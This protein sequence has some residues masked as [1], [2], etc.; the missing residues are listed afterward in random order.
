MNMGSFEN[1]SPV[2]VGFTSEMVVVGYIMKRM[3]SFP[4]I[5]E[6]IVLFLSFSTCIQFANEVLK[7]SPLFPK[8]TILT[9]ILSINF[10]IIQIISLRIKK[11][12]SLIMMLTFKSVSPYFCFLLHFSLAKTLK[13]NMTFN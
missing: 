3:T 10:S 4:P 12:S 5:L 6:Q 1:N 9:H 7:E 13:Q 11:H 2:V 8:Y